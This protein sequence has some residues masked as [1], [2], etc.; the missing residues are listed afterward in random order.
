MT[1]N[2]S[3]FKPGIKRFLMKAGTYALMGA[4]IMGVA[5]SAMAIQ[6]GKWEQGNEADFQGGKREE[7]VVS[8]LGEVELSSRTRKLADLPLDF[9]AIYDA[10]V[11]PNG[12]VYLAAGS[13]KSEIFKWSGGKLTSVLSL[14]N[15]QVF[16][17]A[18]DK[19]GRLLVAV[20]AEEAT[21]VGVLENGKL[22][23]LVPLDGVRYVWDMA[24]VGDRLALA[25]GTPGRLLLVDLA[26]ADGKAI[27]KAETKPADTKPADTKPAAKAEKD[28]E[29]GE[30]VPDPVFHRSVTQ[31][32]KSK[33]NNLLCLGVGPNM[34]LYA[35]SDT[36]GLVYRVML[37]KDYTAE[38]PMVIFDAPEPEIGALLVLDDGTV[39]A[40]TADVSMA[41]AAAG[42]EMPGA[43]LGRAGAG[44]HPG[45]VGG[46]GGTG[47]EEGIGGDEGDGESKSPAADKKSEGNGK[48][49]KDLTGAI[50]VG[51]GIKPTAAGVVRGPVRL[52]AQAQG[53]EPA[54]N[55]DLDR[56]RAA[57]KQKIEAGKKAGPASDAS[58][59]AM[60]PARRP[61]AGAAAVRPGAAGEGFMPGGMAGPGG[62]NAVY[63][64]TP[65]GFVHE[66][67]RDN[68]MILRIVRQPDGKLL[69]GTGNNGVLYRLDVAAGEYAALADLEPEQIGTVVQLPSGQT[70]LATSNPGQLVELDKGYAKSGTIIS[71]V[72]DAAQI[73]L[74]GNLAVQYVAPAGTKVMIQTR[75]GNVQD[76]E[77]GPWSKWSEA[78]ELKAAQGGA[79]A[80]SFTQI[81]SPPAR[82][83]QYKV[84]LEGTPTV[85]PVLQKVDA[86]YVVPNL[87]P[88]IAAV[89]V[90]H[91]EDQ[92]QMGPALNRGMP[93]M[94]KQ[95]S[96]GP[97]PGRPMPNM[98]PGMPGETPEPTGNPSL[99]VEWEAADPNNDRMN[100]KLEYR[101]VGTTVWLPVAKDAKELES[102][103]YDWQTLKVPDGRYQVRLTA[104]DAPDN[105]PDMTLTAQRVSSIFIVDN[106]P[107]VIEGIK[108]KQDGGTAT[109][110]GQASDAVSTLRSIHYTVDGG[111]EWKMVVPDDMLF[112]ST[113]ES[114]TIK[115]VGLSPGEHVVSVRAVDARGNPKYASTSIQVK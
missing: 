102:G 60:G 48:A 59:N 33:Q 6:P 15:E 18:V 95:V 19:A 96:A 63:R 91:A 46:G 97:R 82:F 3:R 72:F 101:A 98:M 67:F 110:T 13:E 113:K 104:T 58:E 74:W 29:A 43:G 31:L 87:R 44:G 34:S 50:A 106:T 103:P 25:A 71:S 64:I 24:M 7:T 32:L 76:P 77:N 65:D 47:P 54:P 36:E 115:I 27:P 39:F 49:S 16:A 51:A 100:F 85:T 22:T 80:P 42:M 10:A 20:S 109:I 89:R 8:S 78:V 1:Q 38:N 88:K 37:K 83:L 2:I 57:I 69:I 92:P 61:R 62:A 108:F 66:A 70:L 45:S 93:A 79:G 41:S 4:L 12:D 14:T 40:G 107:P 5:S 90:T 84:T 105:P 52:D 21:R 23:T 111:T 26:K 68:A 30:E 114:F 55:A 28:A 56:L 86:T 9:N 75:S 112:D 81:Q 94:P 53:A 17:L 99:N 73:S 35:G 11:L